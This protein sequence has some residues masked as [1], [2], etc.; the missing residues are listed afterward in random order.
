M[1]YNLTAEPG[2]LRIVLFGALTAQEL[3]SL[4][5]EIE[6][7]ERGLPMAPHRLSDLS[8]ISNPDVGFADVF[9]FAERRKAQSLPNRVKSA[10]VAPRPVNLGYARMFQMLNDNPQIE[11][12][13][14]GT[15]AEAEVWLA[16]T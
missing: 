2:L 8:Q 9:A 6:E 13:I 1:P 12:R 5:A 14:F 16:D 10:L 11:I 7:I 3:Q 15:L 4:A